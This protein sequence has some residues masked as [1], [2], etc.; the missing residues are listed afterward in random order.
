MRIPIKLSMERVPERLRTLVPCIRSL[1]RL[2]TGDFAPEDFPLYVSTVRVGRTWKSTSSRRH[3]LS[4]DLILH[5]AATHGKPVVIDIGASDGTTS[6]ELIERLNGA[7]QRYYV[8]DKIQHIDYRNVGEVSYFYDRE[9][10]RPF[11]RASRWIVVYEDDDALP[12]LGAIS[13]RLLAR[14][15]AY[16][17]GSLEH[18][19][20]DLPELRE[21]AKRD[22]R[23]S[24]CEHD[25]LQPWEGERAHIVKVANV[26]NPSYFS[27]EEATASAVNLKNALEE[28]GHL[29]VIDNRY[30]SGSYL[31]PRRMAPEPVERF[32]LFRKVGG[33]LELKESRNGGADHAP[34]VRRA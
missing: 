13:R 3:A 1:R 20:L 17:E 12:V 23:V 25:I 34:A 22:E 14:A 19:S 5:L 24:I 6:F 27:D 4:D 33:R 9:T 18:L 32:S 15:P 10:K 31:Q 28:G 8:T 16:E 30:D 21:L 29:L 11:L 7:F 2:V 26:L